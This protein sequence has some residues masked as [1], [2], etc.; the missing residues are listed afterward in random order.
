MFK[1][2][3][4]YFYYLEKLWKD[5]KKNKFLLNYNLIKILYKI[6]ME[7]EEIEFEITKKPVYCGNQEIV[8]DGYSQ[9]G[10]RFECMKKGYG[11]ALYNAPIE[12]IQ[13]VRNKKRKI[14]VLTTNEV[15][16]IAKRLNITIENQTIPNLINEIVR[17]L[18]LLII[19]LNK[20]EDNDNEI[21]ENIVEK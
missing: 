10:T 21:I 2:H 13:R 9:L 4:I 12:N 11:S 6:K 7:K 18:T 5:Y 17:R 19:F 20:N 15:Y 16:K 8:P 14:R 1:N 3:I